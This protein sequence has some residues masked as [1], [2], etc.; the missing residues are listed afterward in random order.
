MSAIVSER[1]GD[2]WEVV[3]GLEVHCRLSTL[4]KLFCGCRNAFGEEPN[5][6]VCEVCTGQP[7]ALPVLNREAVELAV[8]AALAIGAEVQPWSKFD[9]KNYFYCDLPKGYQISQFDAPYCTGGGIDLAS[10]KRC[11]LTRIHLEEDAGKAIH[12]RGTGTLVDLNRCGAPLIESVTEPDLATAAEAHEYLSAL[13]ETFQYAGVSDCDMEK[14]SLRCDVNISV[15]HP[16]EELGTKVELKNLNSF[17]SVELAIDHEVARQ[18]EVLETGGAIVQETRLFDVEA[19]VTRTMRV[20]EDAHDY[21]YFPDPDLPPVTV[22]AALIERQLGMLPE[23][24]AMRRER[25]VASLGL[26][27][28]DAVVLTASRAVAD[29]FEATVRLAGEPKVVANWITNG[30]SELLSDP[31]VEANAIDELPFRAI[32][33][34]ELVELVVEGRVTRAAGRKLLRAMVETSKSPKQLMHELDLER[35]DDSAALE[36]WC[37]AALEGRDDVAAEVRAG[38]DKALGALMGPVMKAS[39]GK[40]EPGA[41][42]EMLLRLIRGEG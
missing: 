6:L 34:A 32:D 33:L 13:K 36:G 9:R 28:Y 1:T 15:R 7:G 20:K 24:P 16:G 38:K 14:G 10:G 12:D 27:E 41:V 31:N 40:A 22:G 39:G 21:R 29:F 30:V 25:Y 2:A 42:R 26:S 35:V 37:R 17:S 4:T 8:R 18:I 5:T 11:R 3:I 19:G 23:L